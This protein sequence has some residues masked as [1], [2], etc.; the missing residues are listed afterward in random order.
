MRQL[1]FRRSARFAIVWFRKIGSC[2]VRSA[3]PA[4]NCFMEVA[5]FGGSGVVIRVVVHCVGKI[6]VMSDL[7]R[8]KGMGLKE[9][10]KRARTLRECK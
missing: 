2:R 8:R 10:K 5:C 3:R 1:T 7:G 4:R 6:L 9:F